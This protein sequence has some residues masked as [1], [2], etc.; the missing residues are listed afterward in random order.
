[1][2][3]APKGALLFLV[4]LAGAGAVVVAELRSG[5]SALGERSTAQRPSVLLLTALPLLFNEEFSLSD[6]GSPALKR[7][8]S[9]YRVVPISVTNA[10]ELAKGRLL[11]MAQPQAQTAENL[12]A[13]DA[14]VRGGGRV[15]L[16]A[17]PMLEWPSKR[18]FGDPTRPSPMFADTGLL[19]HWGVRLDS[20][21]RRGP[22]ERRLGDYQVAT[23]S[24]G[25]LQGTCKIAPDLFEAKCQ[26]GKG[27]ATIVADADFLNVASD[28][29]SNL[30][31]VLAELA[32]LESK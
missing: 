32:S 11:L 1:M 12:V 13:L 22:A 18:P 2:I 26:V 28:A 17:D 9:R 25:S 4:A 3:R 14:W 27:R 8:Q 6:G 5:P 31:A 29:D 20:P 10:T 23:V 24:P 16:L 19:Q 21:D 7:L 30:D 15:L